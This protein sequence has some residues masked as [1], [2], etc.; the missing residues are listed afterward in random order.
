MDSVFSLNGKTILIT[1]ATSG[2]GKTCVVK[3]AQSGAKIFAVGR[4]AQKL[5]KLKS[6]VPNISV[7]EAD[8]SDINSYNFISQIPEI[9]GAFFCAGISIDEKPLKFLD[10]K[11]IIQTVNTNLL[12]NIMMTR[13]LLKYRKLNR[14]GSI[15]YAASVSG[16]LGRPQ[17][18]IYGT[19]KAGLIYFVKNMAVELAPRKCRVNTISPGMVETP[20][21]ID[22]IKNSPELYSTDLKKHPLG[23]GKPEYIANLVQFLLS[24]ASSWIT[25]TNIPIDGGFSCQK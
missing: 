24:D 11:T 5:E 20:M 2:I 23:Y 14:G 6:E 21:T 8:L 25:G 7:V 18:S 9:N 16:M 12:S 15:V 17:S 10:D 4:D 19:T 1:G 3:F 13:E 22:F